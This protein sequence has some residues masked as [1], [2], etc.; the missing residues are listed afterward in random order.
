MALIHFLNSFRIRMVMTREIFFRTS[1]ILF[2]SLCFLGFAL[3][4]RHG[5]FYSNFISGGVYIQYM[6]FTPYFVLVFRYRNIVNIVLAFSSVL[7]YLKAFSAI[8]F[9]L[10]LGVVV[11]SVVFYTLCFLFIINRKMSFETIES[12]TQMLPIKIFF[13]QSVFMKYFMVSVSTGMLSFL[14]GLKYF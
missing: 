3:L 1:F 12:T 7:I 11:S 14:I 5:D 4:Y 13:S 10:F 8:H 2:I 9:S 6:L